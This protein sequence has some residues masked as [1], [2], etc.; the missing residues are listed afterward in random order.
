VSV[1]GVGYAASKI[2]TDDIKAQAVTKPKI[3]KKAVS[4]GKLDSQAVVTGKI[5]PAA[6]K[7]GKI[8][9]AAV[10]TDKIAD[11]A[12]TGAKVLDNSLSG[13]KIDES[14]LGTVPSA[15]NADQLGGLGA[16][17]YAQRF[18]ARVQ[19]NSSTPSIITSSPGVTAQGEG[20]LGFPRLGFPRSMDSCAVVGGAVTNAGTQIV[21]RSSASTGTLLQ[22]AIKDQAGN[23]I[24]ADFDVVAIC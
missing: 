12:V 2:G 1:G 22:M 3:A 7:G 20:A 23:A 5:G 8:N 9:D 18:F 19:Y 14:T 16:S 21:R 6:V 24:R 15:S 11:Q 13:D 10:S 4:S 17:N